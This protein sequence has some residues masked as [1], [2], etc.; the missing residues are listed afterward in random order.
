MEAVPWVPIRPQQALV[1]LASPALATVPPMQAH[2]LQ[3]LETLL[4]HASILTLTTVEGMV[5]HLPPLMELTAPLVLGLA[6]QLMALMVLLLMEPM[7]LDSVL[8][9]P[10]QARTLQ[11]L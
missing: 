5:D 11:T 4:I 9:K 10:P 1:Q 2:T 8:Q 7:V 3:T 6:P